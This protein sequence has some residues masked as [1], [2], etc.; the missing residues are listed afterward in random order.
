MVYM[1]FYRFMLIFLNQQIMIF[2]RIFPGYLPARVTPRS[3]R[4]YYKENTFFIK[5]IFG[6]GRLP[7]RATLRVSRDP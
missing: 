4:V 3:P 6:S 7:A 2:S 1:V 5:I